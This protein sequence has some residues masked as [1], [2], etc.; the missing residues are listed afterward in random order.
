M[1]LSGNAE[2]RAIRNL[3]AQID[4]IDKWRDRVGRRIV[5]LFLCVF[6]FALSL[7]FYVVK[8]AHP[9][10]RLRHPGPKVPGVLKSWRENAVPA[11]TPSPALPP[12]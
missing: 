11:A 12:K 1:H 9:Q 6:V 8:Y 4:E 2:S 3:I 7:L 5:G 10:P